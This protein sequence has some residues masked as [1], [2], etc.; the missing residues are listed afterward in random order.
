MTVPENYDDDQLDNLDE[1]IKH[2]DEDHTLLS[3]SVGVF[4]V[5]GLQSGTV[6]ATIKTGKVNSVHFPSFPKHWA[7]LLGH[8]GGS[9]G[10]S[11]DTL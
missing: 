6:Q 4:L 10:L 5:G 9:G 1:K 7:A 2:V 8:Q 11:L 3:L